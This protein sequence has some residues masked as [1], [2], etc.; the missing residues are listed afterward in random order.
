MFNNSKSSTLYYVYRIQKKLLKWHFKWPSAWMENLLKYT[1]RYFVLIKN[2][3]LQINLFLRKRVSYT[4][5]K[6][7]SNCSFYR[8][9]KYEH[10]N[11]VPNTDDGSTLPVRHSSD[12]IM[13]QNMC[14]LHTYLHTYIHAC[15]HTY[16]NTYIYILRSYIHII[17]TYMRRW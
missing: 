7:K 12:S 3:S 2:W 10:I 4:N 13:F 11:D 1:L 8:N 5:P 9:S 15:I 14:T 17:I 16:I 6:S